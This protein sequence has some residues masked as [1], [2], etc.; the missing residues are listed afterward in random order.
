MKLR[1][2]LSFGVLLFASV[3]P[4]LAQQVPFVIRFQS[5]EQVS[6]VP[7]QASLSMSAE[8]V[9]AT[10]TANLLLTYRGT[11]MATF[12]APPSLLGSADFSISGPENLPAKIG[13][14]ASV[15][16]TVA[17]RARTAQAVSALLSL[18]YVEDPPANA[19]TGMVGTQ[20]N[21]SLI[22]SGTAPSLQVSYFIQGEGNFIPLAPG[23]KVIFFDIP[24]NTSAVAV[25]SIQNR[26][27]GSGT[28][29]AVSLAGDSSFQLLGVPL[30]PLAVDAQQELR[31]P[32][33][34]T[35]RVVASHTATLKVKIGGREQVFGVDGSSIGPSFSYEYLESDP[36]RPIS[37]NNAVALPDTNLNTPFDFTVRVKNIGNA[38]GIF[39]SISVSGLGFSV[40]DTPLFPQTLA[41]GASFLITVRFNP[42]Q[43]GQLRGR[44]R[45]GNETLEFV[46]R[47]IGPLLEYSFRNGGFVSALRAGDT[48]LF[49]PSNVGGST[50]VVFT[51]KNTGTTRASISTV[52]VVDARGP[53]QLGA[54]SN[55]PLAL[56]PEQSTEFEIVYTPQVAGFATGILRVDTL[57]FNLNGTANAPPPLPAFRFEGLSGTLEPF[58]QVSVG[59][60]L[61]Q[62][63]PLPIVGSLTL[64]V[65]P[66]SFVADP[67]VQF[68]TGGRVVEFTIAPNARQAVFVNGLTTVRLQTGSV[69]GLLI[70]TPSFR[71]RTGGSD[72]TPDNPLTHRINVPPL[73]PRVLS[74]RI[75][76]RT[77]NG[78]VLAVTGYATTRSLSQLNIELTP[79]AG[80]VLLE[81]LISISIEA[82]MD[83][84]FRSQ[85]AVAFGGQFTIQIP[86]NIRGQDTG[87]TLPV[88]GLEAVVVT[89]RNSQ[90]LSNPQRVVV[91][92]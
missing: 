45:V 69:S 55:L 87:T 30:L 86:L 44:L 88:D 36:V 46:G 32:I 67:A 75:N 3:L 29:E 92:Q 68:A 37:P 13:P 83:Q 76:S 12:S 56:E 59:L 35:P 28:L 34:Y 8:G 82:E 15:T 65:N 74:A 47:G 40:V 2:S 43:P 7:N 89:V 5:G 22:F 77:A 16:I 57:N 6:N 31:I 58:Q 25:V 50:R 90:G 41:A 11:T 70:L 80:I 39:Q 17:Y 26:G 53:F 73:A 52:G 72:I 38:D 60:T 49:S 10:R 27:S 51:A 85:A 84:W 14:G 54:L 20:G 79:V 64:S 9:G 1:T 24:V 91:R 81:R 78:V 33:R 4:V 48:V 61:D 71:T 21:I 18:A 42:T 62:P 19:P 63:Y 23:G 66:D